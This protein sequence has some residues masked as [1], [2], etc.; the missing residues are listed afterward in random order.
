MAQIQVIV[1]DDESLQAYL[2]EGYTFVTLI[3][4]SATKDY[5]IV[6]M[7]E[8]T[9]EFDG[10]ATKIKVGDKVLIEFTD[11]EKTVPGFNHLVG[12][13]TKAA[14]DEPYCEI[15]G[16]GIDLASCGHSSIMHKLNK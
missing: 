6:I 13:L 7:K 15:D 12:I 3:D 5:P 16:V 11:G 1:K 9:I 10:N 14:K 2:N 8:P 4:R